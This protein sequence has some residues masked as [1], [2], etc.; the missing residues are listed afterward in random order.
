MRVR[1]EDEPVKAEDGAWIISKKD[2][3][4]LRL[5]FFRENV[6]E[7]LYQIIEHEKRIAE[8]DEEEP[9]FAPGLEKILGD[10]ALFDTFLCD[11]LSSTA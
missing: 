6:K 7:A 5:A 8:Q 11:I 3:D 2:E 10:E 4:A 1:F 9:C